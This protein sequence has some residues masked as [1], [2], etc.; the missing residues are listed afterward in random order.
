MGRSTNSW[1]VKSGVDGRDG[2]EEELVVKMVG[3]DFIEE[4]EYTLVIGG[5]MIVGFK[6][7]MIVRGTSAK[8]FGMT[9]LKNVWLEFSHSSISGK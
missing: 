9:W 8:V 4:G 3:V 1:F 7:G 2:G 6:T 5:T